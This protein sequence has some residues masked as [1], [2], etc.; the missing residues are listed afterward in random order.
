VPK[1]YDADHPQAELLKR[2]AFA[3]HIAAGGLAGPG[4]IPS[5]NAL[6][7]AMLPIWRI[8]DRTF[9]G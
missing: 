1:P 6:V 7:P 4:L 8:L 2:K 9:P 5:L 3:V